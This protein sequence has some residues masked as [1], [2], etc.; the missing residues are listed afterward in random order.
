[1]T[2]VIDP[3]IVAGSKPR[4][5]HLVKGLLHDDEVDRLRTSFATT[6]AEEN[7]TTHAVILV[8]DGRVTSPQIYN[9]LLSS[10]LEDRILPYVRA[11]LGDNRLVVADALMRAYQDADRRQALAPHFDSSSYATVII[12]LNAG[13]GEYEGGLYVQPG[14]DASSRILVDPSFDKGDALVHRFDVMH[15]VDVHRG[16]R[17][18][19]VLWLSDCEE[20]A[21]A[22]STPWLRGAADAGSA[23]AQF[24][25]AEACK[26]GRDGIEKDIRKAVEYQQR[27]AAQGHALS[28]HNLGI[29]YWGGKGVGQSDATCLSLWRRAAEAGLAAAQV[30]MGMCYA[31][32]RLGLPQNTTEA[33]RWYELAGAQG[34]AEAL[35][36]LRHLDWLDSQQQPHLSSTTV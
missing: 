33:R 22:G 35:E 20:S 32:G 1:M 16:D 4:E 3:A 21:R 19:L 15:G 34:N 23:F 13:T 5:M 2:S 27:A 14:A 36:M 25:Y 6:S 28:Q 29:L 30:S 9:E 26:V 18:S 8:E 7:D 11:R 24:L 12:P 10:A 31:N 17:Y